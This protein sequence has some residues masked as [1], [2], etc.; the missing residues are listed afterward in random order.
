MNLTRNKISSKAFNL[1]YEKPEKDQSKL[2]DL[3]VY[4]IALIQQHRK[5]P[6]QILYEPK[7]FEKKIMHTFLK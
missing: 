3:F 4:Q 7:I 2:I 5:L 1:Y 6:K